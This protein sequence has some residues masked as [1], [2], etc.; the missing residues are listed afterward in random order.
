MAK[1]NLDYIMTEKEMEL[2]NDN[3]DVLHR[4]YDRNDIVDEDIKSEFLM[5]YI[6]AIH[7]LYKKNLRRCDL[8]QRILNHLNCNLKIIIDGFQY[9]YEPIDSYEFIS[10]DVAFESC[11]AEELKALVDDILTRSSWLNIRE[12]TIIRM[13]YGIGYDHECTFEEIAK[14]F[15]VT[16]QRIEQIHKDAL[17]KLRHARVTRKLKD[18]VID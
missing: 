15:N 16:V 2:A 6:K 10:N 3:L 5:V 9:I 4:F 17:R 12:K 11:V 18:Y 14:T 8:R 7:S 13:Y 1:V